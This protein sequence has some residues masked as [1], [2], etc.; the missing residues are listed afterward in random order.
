[1]TFLAEYGI[2][3]AKAVTIVAAILVVVAGVLGIAS[4]NKSGSTGKLKV[5]KLNEKLKELKESMEVMLFSDDELKK[6]K[7]EL[8]QKAKAEKKAKLNKKDK[9]SKARVFILDFDG[10]IKASA[11]DNFRETITS[12]L[13]VAN[14]EVDEVV[15]RLESGGGMVHA[16]GLA[17]AQ[18]DRIKQKGLKLTVCVD[19]VAASGGYMMAC[20]A[21]HIVASPFAVMGS[22]GVVAQLPN[23]NRLLKKNEIDFE[24]FTAGEHKR[25][26]TMFGENTDKGREKFKEDLEDTHELFKGFVGEHRPSVNLTQ[27]ANGDVWFGRRAL[28]VNLVDELKTSDEY[29]LDACQAADVYEVSYEQKKSIGERFGIAVSSAMER[30]IV[31][32]SGLTQTSNLIK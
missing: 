30:A 6:Q 7:K 18:M 5:K 20:V 32:L 24:L 12:V 3:L 8:K 19:K 17:A 22:I 4:K 13:Q 9:E 15:V 1:M 16:Y 2:F 23:F 10:D 26:V 14:P 25:T 29:I 28:D 11:N 21:D 31:K 27:V